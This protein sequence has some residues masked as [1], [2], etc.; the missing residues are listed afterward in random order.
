VTGQRGAS[1][2]ACGPGKVNIPESMGDV[3]SITLVCLSFL[4]SRFLHCGLK[5]AICEGDCCRV[6]RDEDKDAWAVCGDRVK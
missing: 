5:L 4:A 3:S 1:T 2:V 6:A